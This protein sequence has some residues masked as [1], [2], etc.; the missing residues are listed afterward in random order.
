MKTKDDQNGEA[1]KSNNYVPKM[2]L[3]CIAMSAWI[4]AGMHHIFH[5]IVARVVL[6]FKQFFKDEDKNTKFETLVNP[7][8]L[9]MASQRLDWLHIKPLPKTMWLIE[10]E[11]GLLRIM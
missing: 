11:L 9:E 4:E 8:L 3:C 1:I 2:W 10:D 5:G 7:Y 6:L